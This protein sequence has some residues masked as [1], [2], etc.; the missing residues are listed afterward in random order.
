MSRRKGI[1]LTPE[2]Q[3]SYLAAAK[4]VTLC[5]ID[6]DG[7]PHS[8][9]M[10][11]DTEAD[12]TVWMTTYRKSQKVVNI[13]RNPK[14]SLSVESGVTYDTL[15]G[16]LIRG[17]AKLVE[18]TETV[19]RLLKRIHTKMLGSLPE[20]IDEALRAQAA[21]RVAIQIQPKKISSWDHS[22]LAGGY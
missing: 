15:K 11:F 6:R 4:T 21:K 10:W 17:D 13:R 22:K 8:V 14:V 3:Q 1:A 7:Y 16:L 19:F 12:N 20:G 18:H 5:T 9:A 2:Q